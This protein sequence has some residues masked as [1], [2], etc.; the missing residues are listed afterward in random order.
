MPAVSNA[1][2]TVSPARA[3]VR[4]PLSVKATV[5]PAASG[6]LRNMEP[7]GTER[8]QLVGKPACRDLRCNI[9]GVIRGERHAGMARGQ[10]R[11]RM[12][13]RLIVDWEAVLAH[14]P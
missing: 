1:A 3:V 10:E 12:R 7:P 11:A 13:A 9:E 8:N 14:H 2:A 6:S 5:S 4:A